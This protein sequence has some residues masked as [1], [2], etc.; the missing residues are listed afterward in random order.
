MRPHL[1]A[2]WADRD[3]V[4]S[5]VARQVVQ[6]PTY[7]ASPSS[8]VWIGMTR[9]L[10]RVVDGDPFATPTDADQQAAMATGI[11]GGRAG[12]AVDDLVA[13]VLLGAR[14]VEEEI[15]RRAAAAE[16]AEAVRSEASR[17]ARRWAEQV[18]VWA[19][20]GLTSTAGAETADAR[21]RRLLDAMQREDADVA[22]A[23]LVSDAG[24]DPG[25]RH[26]VVCAVPDGSPGSDVAA[27]AL[28]FAHRG[29]AAWA[30]EP[31]A[32]ETLGVLTESPDRVPGLVVALAG[33]ARSQ[34]L[35]VALREARRV[36]RA[37]AAQVG[38]GL[39][40]A[41]SLGL[42][43]ALHEDAALRERL[44]RRWVHPLLE[45]PRHDLVETLR[46]WQQHHGRTDEVARQL[47]VHTNTVRN[48]LGRVDT[49]LGP[50]WRDP[51]GQAEVWAALRIGPGDS[52]EAVVAGHT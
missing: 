40:T 16:V 2:V 26:V 4:V 20:Q 27:T 6:L 42:L 24:L 22:L 41:E 52:M 50:G 1:E 23:D 18:V 13:A 46:A 48:R 47:G 38:A 37:A 33:A 9:I 11:Q 44:W 43:L 15:L 34:D 14:E 8:E 17:R 12:I 25:G 29:R 3:Q 5:R 35:P 31:T 45:E 28:R 30:E 19:V 7:A 21:H 49:L 51:Q 36:N 39:H 10:E 32:G